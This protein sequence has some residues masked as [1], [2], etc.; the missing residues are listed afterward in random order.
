[1]NSDLYKRPDKPKRLAVNRRGEGACQVPAPLP[2]VIEVDRFSE[3]HV[4]PLEIAGRMVEYLGPTGDYLT[5]EPSA[6]TGS[7]LIALLESGHSI[8]ET[9]AIEFET[10]R[11]LRQRQIFD[12]RTD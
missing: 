12:L 1:M 9:V 2:E 5:L 10:E 4:T 11:A 6:G 8:C 3:C 7:L